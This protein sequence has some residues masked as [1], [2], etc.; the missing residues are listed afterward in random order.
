M[1]A[2]SSTVFAVTPVVGADLD[3]KASGVNFQ[4]APLTPTFA[5]DGRKHVVATAVGTLASTANMTIGASG[6]AIAAASAGVANSY[7]VN[8]TGGVVAGQRF[9]ARSNAL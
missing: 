5:N 3:A 9:W 8:T 6:S 4:F 2:N 7:T 1:A